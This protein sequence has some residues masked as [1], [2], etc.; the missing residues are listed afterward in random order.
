MK[1]SVMRFPE[2][3]SVMVPAALMLACEACSAT[4]G[5][6]RPI[7]EGVYLHA[8]DG[9]GRAVA[10]DGVRLFV[11]SF[12][13]PETDERDMPEWLEDGLVISNVGLCERVSLMQR[14]NHADMIRVTWVKGSSSVTLTDPM[15]HTTFI[16]DVVDGE[17]PGYERLF[18]AE[19]FGQMDE[20]GRPIGREWQAL[21]INSQYLRKCSDVAD[22][23]ETGLEE[24]AKTKHGMVIR[25]FIGGSPM[26]PVVFTFDKWPGTILFLLPTVLKQRPLANETALVVA[27]AAKLTIAALRAHATRN[28]QWAVDAINETARAVFL[29]K[30]AEFD[31]RV[32]LI[33][34]TVPG[35]SAL[36]PAAAEPTVN[37]LVAS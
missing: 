10:T 7:A 34:E 27:P 37:A 26:A 5:P 33:S 6:G 2:Q 30:A 21:G 24:S 32:R 20:F 9:V 19:S 1:P 8:K 18:Q 13:L 35:V 12:A 17:F 15:K 23:L 29:A 22:A 14:W 11:G 4:K 16:T 3:Q 31:E 36:V 25:T 28:R